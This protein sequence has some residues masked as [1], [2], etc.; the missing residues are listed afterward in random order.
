MVA[1]KGRDHDSKLSIGERLLFLSGMEEVVAFFSGRWYQFIPSLKFN[2]VHHIGNS[3]GC[4]VI[5]FIC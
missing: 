2:S 3:I 4:D 5:P 1:G